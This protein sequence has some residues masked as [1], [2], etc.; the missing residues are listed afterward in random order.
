MTMKK[1]E[2]L[3]IIEVNRDKAVEWYAA[4]KGLNLEDENIYCELHSMPFFENLNEVFDFI[5]SEHDYYEEVP[6]DFKFASQL[7]LAEM[8]EIGATTLAEYLALTWERLVSTPY[9]LLAEDI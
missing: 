3:E 5:Y 2:L 1:S 9:G 6:R 8:L 7:P 4:Q